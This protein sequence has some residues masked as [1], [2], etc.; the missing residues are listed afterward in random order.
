ML[1]QKTS[2]NEQAIAG[3]VALLIQCAR[4]VGGPAESRISNHTV[5]KYLLQEMNSH[6]HEAQC[7]YGPL[8]PNRALKTLTRDT[9]AEVLHGHIKNSPDGC[10][11]ANCKHEQKCTKQSA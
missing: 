10:D 7:G 11:C 6:T 8:E 1:Q 9:A 3:L 5:M 2:L 4:E